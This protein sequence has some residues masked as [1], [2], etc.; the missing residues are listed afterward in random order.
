MFNSENYSIQALNLLDGLIDDY[1]SKVNAIRRDTYYFN[2]IKKLRFN[3]NNRYRKISDLAEIK[4]N[5]SENFCQ[6]IV[7]NSDYMELIISE[8]ETLNLKIK[9]QGQFLIV[10]KPDLTFNQ[11][12]SIV[13][14]LEKSQNKFISKCTKAKLEPILRAKNAVENNFIDQVISRQVSLNC[15]KI[16]EIKE[17]EIKKITLKKI[18]QILGK[19]FFDKYINE[20]I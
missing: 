11:L 10:N 2:E 9:V 4:N 6:I 12:M 8:L 7:F 16:F 19:K 5:P 14:E 18:K 15:Q 20:I 17:E 3:I 13:D 1:N